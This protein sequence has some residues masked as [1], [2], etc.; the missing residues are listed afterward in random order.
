[1]QIKDIL[2]FVKYSDRTK[3]EIVEVSPLK[4]VNGTIGNM[5]GFR[6]LYYRMSDN[7]K[8]WRN[9]AFSRYHD[10]K[11]IRMIKRKTDHLK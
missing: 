5:S 4:P 1:M 11:G 7:E 9:V 6:L 10:I 3:S 8:D 2:S